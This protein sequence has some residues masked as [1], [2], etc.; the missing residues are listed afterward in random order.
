MDLNLRR[1]D[2]SDKAEEKLTPDS[3]KSLLDK[4]K[5]GVTDTGKPHPY[6]SAQLSTDNIQVTRSLAAFSQVCILLC[7]FYHHVV[8]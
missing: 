4:T 6:P 1:K 8:N 5:E 3:Q 7:S 2:F